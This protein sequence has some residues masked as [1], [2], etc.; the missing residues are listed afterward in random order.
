MKPRGPTAGSGAVVW[1]ISGVLC[2]DVNAQ[3]SGIL[4][5][6]SGMLISTRDSAS[7]GRV[8][9][10]P[11]DNVAFSMDYKHTHDPPQRPSFLSPL[12]SAGQAPA[13][14]THPCSAEP[15]YRYPVARH[16]HTRLD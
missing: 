11:L 9:T 8:H 12:S 1:A 13:P 7:Y 2:W 15:A 6:A 3:F 10:S 14:S 5:G 4:F 16:D